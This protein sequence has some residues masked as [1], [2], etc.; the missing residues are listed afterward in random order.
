MKANVQQAQQPLEF[1]TRQEKARRAC[2]MAG[3]VWPETILPPGTALYTSGVD[4]LKSDRAAWRRLPLASEVVGLVGEALREE[5]RRDYPANVGNLRFRLTDGRLVSDKR[6]I[7]DP[8]PEFGLGYG[9]HTLRQLVAQIDPLDDA[10]RGFSSALMYLSDQERARILNERIGRTDPE[11]AVTLRTR[12]PHT[13]TRICRAALSKV[14]GSVTDHDIAKAVGEMLEGD[15]TGKLDYKPGDDR[16]RFEIVWPSEIPVE[17]FVVGDVHYGMLSIGNGDTGM[18]SLRIA[19]AVVRARCA[20]LT[21]SVGQGTE[22]VIRHVGQTEELV[23]RLKRAIRAALD[24]MEPLLAVIAGSAR[25]PLDVKVWTP[26][27]A[28]GAIAKRYQLPAATA[29]NWLSTFNE[30]RYPESIW[31]LGA[32]ISEGAHRGETWVDEHE[33]ERIGSL[34]QARAVEVVRAGTPHALALEKALAIN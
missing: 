12:M 31:G 5:D 19:P 15:K 8:R 27:K 4:K 21:I 26:E 1:E 10:P 30:S 6:F 24:D 33:Q 22:V 14:Y 2:E 20:N 3:I 34:V 11:T 29:E 16:S 25:I 9:D 13:G 18:S 32:A 28:L 17:T 23:F 7:E